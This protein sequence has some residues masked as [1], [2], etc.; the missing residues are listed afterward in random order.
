LTALG[1]IGNAISLLLE[2]G[3]RVAAVLALLYSLYLITLQNYWVAPLGDV[4]PLSLGSACVL[5]LLSQYQFSR[6]GW[7]KFDSMAL[8]LLFA[9]AF[10]QTY[11]IVYHFTFPIYSLSFPF[12]QGSDLR[13][14]LVTAVMVLPLVLMRKSLSFRRSGAYTLGA[15]AL[16]MLVWVLFGFPQYFSSTY[17]FTPVLH[18]SDPYHL[19]LLLNYVSK[20][21]L[22]CFFATLLNVWKKGPASVWGRKARAAQPS[23]A[24]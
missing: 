14:L 12:I 20:L 17:Y 1:F 13:F 24:L 18:T 3:A 22:A 19:S 7:G 6:D 15:F 21:I 23:S 16:S 2:W 5:Y 9:D 8:G 11:E 10:L 4:S